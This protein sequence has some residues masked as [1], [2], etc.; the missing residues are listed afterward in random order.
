MGRQMGRGLPAGKA[1]ARLGLV[2]GLIGLTGPVGAAC[3]SSDEEVV[4]ASAAIEV[5]PEV[6][7]GP[8]APVLAAGS[9]SSFGPLRAGDHYL[10]AWLDSRK[11]WP[12]SANLGR[13]LFAARVTDD[14]AVL[15]PVGFPIV[16]GPAA[17]L[18]T[19]SGACSD[20]G[21]C[22][23]VVGPS[24]GFAGAVSGV[25]VQDD[26]VLD[27]TPFVIADGAAL[28]TARTVAWDG[29]QFRVVYSQEGI[30]RSVAVTEA[31][32]IGAPVEVGLDGFDPTIGCGGTRCLVVTTSQD[33]SNPT[34]IGRLLEPTGPVGPSF[35]ISDPVGRPSS[36][37]IYWDGIRFWLGYL[38]LAGELGVRVYLVRV[39]ANGLV[40]D[41][42]GITIATAPPGGFVL[43]GSIGRA[44]EGLIV[45]WS[46]LVSFP[47]ERSVRAT[48]VQLDGTVLDPAGVDL[49]T[50][51]SFAGMQAPTL[52]C[53][54]DTCL[55]TSNEAVGDESSVRGYRLDGTILLDPAGI[56]VSTA[57]PGQAEPAATYQAGR[58]VVVW[59]DARPAANSPQTKSIHGVL[60]PP[61]MDSS[62][63]FGTSVFLGGL[64]SSGCPD[65]RDP[66]VAATATS[67]MVTWHEECLP[68]HV[69]ESYAQAFGLDGQPLTP[70][71][72]VG[73]R[74]GRDARPSVVSDGSEFVVLWDY[75]EPTPPRSIQMRRYD[76]SGAPL[77]D[78][79]RWNRNGTSAVAAF[80]GTNYLVVWQ[81]PLSTNE[82]R[83]DV[84][85]GR[86]APDGTALDVDIPIATL[87][88][89][90]EDA[91]SVACG[92]GVC[93]VAWRH[94]A[95]QVRAV[96]LG[97][98]GTV[99]DA[100][101]MVFPT[102]GPV[103]T[104]SLTFDGEAF[105]L[106]WETETHE[107]HAAQITPA[108]EIIA[109][110]DFVIAAADPTARHPVV[111]SNRA[112]HRIA[113][114]ER[115]DG[116]PNTFMRRLRAR[117]IGE[118]APLPDAGVPDAAVPDAA[119]PDASLPDAAP[120]DG[121][122]DEIDYVVSA[123][124]NPPAAAV[125]GATFSIAVTVR[126]SG[127]AAA[128]ATSTTRFFLSLDTVVGGD[129]A[130]ARSAVVPPLAGGT[131][132][133]QTLDM[134]VPGELASGSYFL[135]A[136]AD[137][138]A[139]VPEVDEHNNCRA[140]AGTVAL[141]GPDLVVEAVGQP[142]P[143]IQIGRPFSPSDTT[144]N[145]G[146]AAA[147]SSNVAYYLS[148]V[149][150]RGPTARRL[151]TTRPTGP[152]GVGQPSSGAVTVTVPAVAAGDY[153]VLACAD[154]SSA[155][156]ELDEQNNCAASAS[157]TSVGPPAV[158]RQQ[159][160]KRT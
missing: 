68:R 129:R 97:L 58:Y 50:F 105:L 98:D 156:A 43:G 117:V 114:V 76:A 138:G 39:S 145:L 140:S 19:A 132:D 32:A 148:P 27:P 42:A 103:P 36:P 83:P 149:P 23:L 3:S 16:T 9:Q 113:M 70:A 85:A 66:R 89:I 100:T 127:G 46:R 102:D 136:C 35:S 5:G 109:P 107:M 12:D 45:T 142:P 63:P 122:V 112:G 41:L 120:P 59:R 17:I 115:Y 88:S 13:D 4:S 118:P 137:R 77:T 84:F 53:G 21:V 64:R 11:G 95:I 146:T 160:I 86:M 130:L 30:I 29:Q 119:P 65:Q 26:Q 60:F 147:A 158:A 144:R 151:S 108:G 24:P 7:V 121:G 124:G 94:A 18:N 93:L 20:D 126:N 91:H 106:A 99:L 79:V 110:G 34:S 159:R 87:P 57:P 125:N 48:R 54:P 38:D 61:T 56:D 139:A 6:D 141:T 74:N 131:S 71:L 133:T 111:V 81:R 116:S 31:G 15:D 49:G 101:P 82:S 135:L 44:D 96:R 152:I 28:S 69:D 150:V 51:S 78:R 10:V 1:A 55:A 73:N 154:V 62:V 25:R 2:V 72:D 22:L 143:S 157:T 75:E 37:R 8:A 40:L 134:V 128:E 52:A 33:F 47:F 92:G 155:V 123:L 14:G 104:T 67:V 90:P 80:D 153:F